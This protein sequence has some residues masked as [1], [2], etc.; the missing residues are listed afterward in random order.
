M[1]CNQG[2]GGGVKRGYL[3]WHVQTKTLQGLAHTV[4]LLHN[5]CVVKHC[6]QITKLGRRKIMYITISVYTDI[7][8]NNHNN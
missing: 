5:T 2:A 8:Y 6:L 7:A 4:I 3:P 1:L